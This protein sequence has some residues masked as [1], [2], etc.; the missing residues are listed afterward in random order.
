MVVFI[1]YMVVCSVCLYLIL[2]ILYSN[3]YICSVLGIVF[4]CVVL[5]IVCVNVYCTTATGCQ[6]NCSYQI[7]HIIYQTFHLSCLATVPPP[8]PL[9]PPPTPP[10]IFLGFNFSDMNSGIHNKGYVIF[11]ISWFSGSKWMY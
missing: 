7:Y 11:C 6:P 3:C 2:C 1:V 10:L 5:C 9:S 8:P 4:H